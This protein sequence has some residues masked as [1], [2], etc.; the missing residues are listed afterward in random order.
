LGVYLDLAVVLNAAVDFFLLMGTNTLAGFPSDWKRVAAAAVLGGIYGGMCVLPGFAFL[1]KL[2]WRIIFLG[3]MAS[4]AF[5]W[6]RGSVKRIGIFVLLSMAMGG[7]ALGFGQGRFGTLLLSGA[8][9][10]LLCRLSFGGSVGQREYVPLSIAWQGREIHVLALKDSGNTLRDPITGEQVLV[11]SA[12]AAA[13]LTGLTPQQLSAPL[14]TMVSGVL[15]GLRL[16][17][18]HSVGQG[19][20]MMLAMRFEDVKIGSRRQSALIAFAARGL[21]EETMY[22]ALTGGM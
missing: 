22:Q 2:I 6:N 10:W 19:S 8:L 17:P 11:L 4:A 1:G 20:G 9:V 14:E 16:V 21:G 12:D 7:I 15:P 13:E 18:Y 3:L 5:G